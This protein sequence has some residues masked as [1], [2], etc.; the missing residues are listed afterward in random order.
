MRFFGDAIAKA[1]D[2]GVKS[3]RRGPANLLQLLPDEFSY[4]EA[5]AIRLEYGLGQKGTRTMINNWVHRGYIERK[6]VSGNAS[7][8]VSGNCQNGAMGQNQSAN[9]TKTDINISNISFENAY[10]IKLKY[11]KDGINIEKNC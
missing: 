11:R 4:Q 8:N 5:M 3:S 2:G 1:E 10:F 7:G 6:S 9:Q